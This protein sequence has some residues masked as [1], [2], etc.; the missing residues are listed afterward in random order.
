M[1]FGSVFWSQA[2]IAEVYTLNA[3]IIAGVLLALLVWGE[4]GRAG[5][6]YA[7]IALFAAGLGN[8]TTIVGLAPGMALYCVMT[9]RPFVTR[10]RTMLVTALILVGGLLQYGFI[11]VRSH[12]ADAYVESRAATVGELVGVVFGR[13]FGNRLFAFDFRSVLVDRLPLLI[14]RLLVPEL[15]LAGFALALI[16]AAWLFRRRLPE[17]LLIGLGGMAVFGFT[18]NYSVVDAHVFLIPT[19]FMLWIAAAVGA[20][21][22]A[23]M[24][25]RYRQAAATAVA[26]AAIALPAWHLAGNFATADRSRST[27]AATT[28]DRLF[29]VIPDRSVL[30]REDFLVDR[31]VMYKLLGDRAAG[32]RRIELVGRNANALRKRHESGSS[33]FAFQRSVRELR[34]DGLN[35]SFRPLPLIEGSLEDYLSRLP[36][37]SVVAIVVP[38][39]HAGRFAAA[40]GTSLTAIG[41]PSRI[42]GTPGIS[43]AI[44][45]ARGSRGEAPIRTSSGDLTVDIGAGD[46][47]PGAGQKIPAAIELRSN[48]LESAIRQGSRDLSRSF[49]GAVMAVWS[50]EGELEQTFVLQAADDFRVSIPSN[51]LSVYALQGV[52]P[53]QDLSNAEWTDVA[54][55]TR[56]GSAMLS[57]PADSTVVAYLGS[58]VRLVPRALD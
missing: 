47:I 37:G 34:H 30:V 44:V 21:Q 14:G 12:Q 1:A 32:D 20:E 52:W 50:A 31:M 5:F 15:T 38:K 35:F 3:A 45:G 42:D 13:Q 22:V 11:I 57:V 17:A 48:G 4:T 10:A 2:T 36:D 23:R 7:A 55:A 27:G 19:I 25:G 51:P 29:D 28:F 39:T 6:F 40:R 54:A 58:T 43:F 56:T 46:V 33:V 9:N 53:R 8:H 41:G 18:L 49:E 26:T 24:G 16:G